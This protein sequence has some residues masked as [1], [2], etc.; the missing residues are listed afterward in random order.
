L[1]RAVPFERLIG[2]FHDDLA[3]MVINHAGDRWLLWRSDH[4]S[5][6]SPLFLFIGDDVSRTS[7][8]AA[9]WRSLALSLSKFIRNVLTGG[10]NNNDGAARLCM[11][12]III[13]MVTSRREIL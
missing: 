9:A 2:P 8:A 7:A 3:A 11:R 5:G 12:G 13:I 6:A 1:A 4:A 10:I